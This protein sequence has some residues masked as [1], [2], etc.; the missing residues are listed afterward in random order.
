MGDMVALTVD[1]AAVQ[2]LLDGAKAR[3]FITNDKI[4]SVIPEVESN[5]VLLDVVLEDLQSNEIPIFENEVDAVTNGFI[6]N[7][8]VMIID[9]GPDVE[10]DQCLRDT[11]RPHF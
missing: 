10:P 2:S 5:L 6:V 1:T 7:R 8:S 11:S 4:L 9:P 3:G